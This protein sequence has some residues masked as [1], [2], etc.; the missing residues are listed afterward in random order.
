MRRPMPRSAR[1]SVSTAGPHPAR[2]LRRSPM[3]SFIRSASAATAP[4]ATISWNTSPTILRTHRTTTP[5]GRRCVNA[6]WPGISEGIT[7]PAI[8][9]VID[10]ASGEAKY[11]FPYTD[12]LGSI[13]TV[14]NV[15]GN[16]IAEQNF[17]AWGR[18]RNASTWDYT[19]V[20]VVPDWLYRGFT[21][22]EHLPE[23]GLINMNAR[24]YDPLLGRM[25]SAD[26]E[27]GD[28]TQGFNRYT[29]WAISPKPLP[30]DEPIG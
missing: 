10:A 13:L 7:C 15:N 14:T 22:H 25:L 6:I 26:N 20:G 12:H 5:A 19:N 30:I 18:K 29:C 8:C 21:E 11:Y 3:S 16:V 4:P 17:D 9:V 1:R 23:F 28:G 27:V 24:L 2:A